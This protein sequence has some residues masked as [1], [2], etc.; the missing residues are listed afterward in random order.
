[1]GY[2]RVSYNLNASESKQ[3]LEVLKVPRLQFLR[4][5]ARGRHAKQRARQ[6]SWLR[7]PHL[8]V[9]WRGITYTGKLGWTVL[10]M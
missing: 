3:F 7:G 6:M 1:M 4:C 10:K 8:T 2:K 5:L 9:G